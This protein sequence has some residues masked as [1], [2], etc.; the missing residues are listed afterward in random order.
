MRGFK[1]AHLEHA[2]AVPQDVAEQRVACG[3]AGQQRPQHR[4]VGQH[5]ALEQ[6]KVMLPR[7][8][9]HIH[10]TAAHSPAQAQGQT[11]VLL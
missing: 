2:G 1:A 8:V 4:T 10:S 5:Q 7:L 6:L 11:Q 3:A 9:A